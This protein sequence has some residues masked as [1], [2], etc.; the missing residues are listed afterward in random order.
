ML[1]EFRK[2]S[3]PFVTI[4]SILFYPNLI[5]SLNKYVTQHKYVT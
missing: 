4:N 5:N 3:V 1:T 2:N